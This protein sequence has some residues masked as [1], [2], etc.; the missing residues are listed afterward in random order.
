MV[1]IVGMNE[2]DVLQSDETENRP[3]VRLKEIQL[4]T[5]CA[6]SIAA[7]ARADHHNL[8]ALQQTPRA[9]LVVDDGFPGGRFVTVV[10][11][12]VGYGFLVGLRR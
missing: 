2:G 9:I 8:L 10:A 6:R 4:G 3:Q 11:L 12:L 5:V 1:L 7:S